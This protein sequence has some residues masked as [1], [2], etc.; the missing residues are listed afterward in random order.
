MTSKMRHF[1]AL[2]PNR[3]ICSP[4]HIRVPYTRKDDESLPAVGDYTVPS[5][6]GFSIGFRVEGFWRL[7]VNPYKGAYY[8]R[9]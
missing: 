2:E 5:Y 8:L 1:S 3:T 4:K 6:Y 7:P 9:C